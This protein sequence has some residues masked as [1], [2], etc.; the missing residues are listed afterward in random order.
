MIR[1]LKDHKTAMGWSIA[2]IKGIS[3]SLCMRRILLEDGAKPTQE[4]Q[5]RLNPPIME[6]VKKE[7]LKLLDVGLIS[8]ISKGKWTS[9]IQVVPKK[10]RVT[11][12]KARNHQGTKQLGV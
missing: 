2:D 1:A 12:I 9:S 11:V 6:V 10:S 7:I 3:P 5:K 4:A 8:L